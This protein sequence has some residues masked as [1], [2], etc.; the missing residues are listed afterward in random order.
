MVPE[1]LPDSGLLRLHKLY[2]TNEVPSWLP[3]DEKLGGLD[4][5]ANSIDGVG[6]FVEALG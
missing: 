4:D 5:P 6:E 2:R 3:G 1:R